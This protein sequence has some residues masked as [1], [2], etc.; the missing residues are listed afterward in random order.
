MIISKVSLTR[1]EE[2]TAVMRSLNKD[3]M[4]LN[5]A[6]DLKPHISYNSENCVVLYFR[7][8][9]LI[10]IQKLNIKYM[11]KYSDLI[12]SL[13]INEHNLFF[14]KEL[15]HMFI[16][17]VLIEPIK[18]SGFRNVNYYFDSFEEEN[19][20]NIIKLPRESEEDYTLCYMTKQIGYPTYI[21]FLNIN[22]K[23][24]I[25]YDFNYI[26]Y[27]TFKDLV[28]KGKL[29]I[30]HQILLC[31]NILNKGLTG[32]DIKKITQRED[33]TRDTL[34]NTVSKYLED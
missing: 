31:G 22:P 6:S 12:M 11:V 26:Q 18:Q 27:D 24:I 13:Y 29:F 2:V 17:R 5:T 14:Y 30:P 7:K 28:F 3:L 21:N 23:S 34:F 33:F 8:S 10:S 32:L 20:Y 15:P 9:N 4:E 19:V 1:K 25:G 16:D